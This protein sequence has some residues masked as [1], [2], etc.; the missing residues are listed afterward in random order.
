[1]SNNEL[2]AI[3]KQKKRGFPSKAP[4]D[5]TLME[6]YMTMTAKEIA[7]Q[8][9]VTEPTVRAWIKNARARLRKGCKID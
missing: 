4:D 8:Y 3:V 9:G 7:A 2:K 6:R 1:M 5:V